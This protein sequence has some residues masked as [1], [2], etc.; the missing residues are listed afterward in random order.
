MSLAVSLVPLLHQECFFFWC[1]TCSPCY[2]FQ[3]RP[4][5][6][7]ASSQTAHPSFDL[8]SAK[9]STLLVLPFYTLVFKISI[10]P[11]SAAISN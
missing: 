6:D 3:L 11:M 2:V 10:H 7:N 4:A 1:N 8:F 5:K 9:T